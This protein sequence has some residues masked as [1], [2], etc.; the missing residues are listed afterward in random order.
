MATEEELAALIA[1]EIFEWSRQS[2]EPKSKVHGGLP[3][4]PF[5]KQEWDNSQIIVHV[6]D[7]LESVIALKAFYPPTADQSHIIAW[8]GWQDMTA[9]EFD[10]WIDDQNS[11]HMGTWLMGFHPEAPEDETVPALELPDDWPETDD[12]AIILMQSLSRVVKAS[13]QLLGTGYYQSYSDD[14]MQLIH[15]RRE[16]LNAWQEKV[17]EVLYRQ[18]EEDQLTAFQEEVDD[19]Q[20]SPHGHQ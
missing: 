16:T 12:Y 17:D 20:E 11:N 1:Q 4:C 9:D 6:T 15:N 13:N 8:L 10:D 14:D 3:V 5:A 18:A 2:L 7:D 19:E